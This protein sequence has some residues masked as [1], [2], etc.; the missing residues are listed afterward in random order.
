MCGTKMSRKMLCLHKI[1]NCFYFQPVVVVD[2]VYDY[3][4]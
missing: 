4:C 1:E 2:L 3:V